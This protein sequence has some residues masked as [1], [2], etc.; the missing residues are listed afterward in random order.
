[1]SDIFYVR[2]DE[3]L[4]C[5]HFTTK[6]SDIP[7]DHSLIK[8]NGLYAVH[9]NAMLCMKVQRTGKDH[10]F[11]V[12]P[13]PHQ[14]VDTVFVRNADDILLDNGT[15]IQVSCYIIACICGYFFSAVTGFLLRI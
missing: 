5:E 8:N 2:I 4:Y 10:P 9:E 11:Q 15:F 6:M 1:M 14:I 12:P 13:F 3:I 7:V